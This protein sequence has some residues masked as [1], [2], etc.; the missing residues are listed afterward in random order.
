MTEW[1][2]KYR[3]LDQWRQSF[4]SRDKSSKYLA[5]FYTFNGI[6]KNKKIHFLLTGQPS[7]FFYRFQQFKTLL[8]G[9]TTRSLS[10]IRDPSLLA[11]HDEFLT[12]LGKKSIFGLIYNVSKI[13]L[14]W[15]RGPEIRVKN[16]ID[17]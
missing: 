4:T 10:P 9:N 15:S 1:S 3:I 6:R 7:L 5:R 14:K 8:N 11:V 12:F 2:S 13:A 16:V 17:A